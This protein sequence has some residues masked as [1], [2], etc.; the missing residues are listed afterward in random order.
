MKNDGA[1][2]RHDQLFMVIALRLAARGLGQVWPNPAVGCV[3]TAASDGKADQTP[4]PRIVGRGWTQP[5][6][7]PHAETEALARAGSRANGGTAYVTLEPCAHHGKTPPCVEALIAAGISRVVIASD[8][9]DP[10]VNGQGV[11]ALRAA[12]IEVTTG[13]C[14]D[15][16]DQINAG[17]LK[18]IQRGLPLLTFKTATTLDGQIATRTGESQWITGPDA[19]RQGHMLRAVHDAI[20][21]GV[22]TIFADN[23]SLTCRLPG[24]LSRSPVRVVADGHLSIPLDAAVVRQAAEHRLLII[25]LENADRDRR[26]VLE[27]IGVEVISVPADDNGYADLTRAMSAL[28]DMGFT[29]ILAECGGR[30]A[31]SLFSGGLVD[32]VV[33]FRAGSLIGGDGQA[34]V[35]GYGLERLHDAARFRLDQQKIVGADIME[36]YTLLPALVKTEQNAGMTKL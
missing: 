20:L 16:G 28:A 27:D 36:A 18:K 1:V 22:G 6:G 7:R 19:R 14:A 24:M 15:S 23:P 31:A 4:L 25:A 30:L 2:S 12:G 3:I 32:R 29:R 13:I 33:W 9:P 5:G 8:D 17:F 11:A 10:R 21:M 34:A 35:A 26:R